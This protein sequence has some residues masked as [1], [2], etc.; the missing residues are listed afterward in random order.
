VLYPYFCNSLNIFKPAL[1]DE[2]PGNNAQA[3]NTGTY[4]SAEGVALTGTVN[5][6]LPVTTH[7]EIVD[8]AVLL[9]SGNIQTSD[10]QL[11]LSKLN[12]NQLT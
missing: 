3:Y 2:K 8:I 11:R 7:S 10:F 5:C 12:L 4:V 1:V 9:A 6:E